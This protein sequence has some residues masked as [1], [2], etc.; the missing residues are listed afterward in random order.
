MTHE[1]YKYSFL[2]K[3]TMSTKLCNGYKKSRS[4]MTRDL[5]QNPSHNTNT[6]SRN[7]VHI[8][9][10][11]SL[12]VNT[13]FRGEQYLRTIYIYIHHIWLITL[14]H[15]G[16]FRCHVLRSFPS[17][18]KYKNPECCRL[19]YRA[20]DFTVWQQT[21]I[22]IHLYTCASS[23]YLTGDNT[24]IQHHT[25]IHTLTYMYTNNMHYKHVKSAAT[26]L[27]LSHV[28]PCL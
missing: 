3:N 18:E 28:L 25:S 2:G 23:Y 12:K 5:I 19:I 26:R 10:L 21:Y 11:N 4:S 1:K 16:I 15:T 20:L 24:T 14:I 9:I 22:H 8:A 27:T 7:T 13:P 17:R 6:Y